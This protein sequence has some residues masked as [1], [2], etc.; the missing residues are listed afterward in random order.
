MEFNEGLKI[1]NGI[2]DIA[3]ADHQSLTGAW[4]GAVGLRPVAGAL[5]R[6]I[7]SKKNLPSASLIAL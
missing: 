5:N 7:S 1:Q 3:V 6:V 4:S 2:I